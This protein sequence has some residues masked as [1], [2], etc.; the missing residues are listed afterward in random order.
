[1]ERKR[2]CCYSQLDEPHTDKCWPTRPI[3]DA[4]W[5]V[6]RGGQLRHAIFATRADST[7]VSLCSQT[8]SAVSIVRADS[9]Y[10]ACGVC[11]RDSRGY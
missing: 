11:E 5:F 6:V 4:T 1:M 7:V 9:D 8:F 2:Y 10:R 3:K